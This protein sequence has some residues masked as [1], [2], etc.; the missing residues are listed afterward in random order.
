MVGDRGRD[1][2]ACSLASPCGDADTDRVDGRPARQCPADAV[3]TASQVAEMRIKAEFFNAL[4]AGQKLSHAEMRHSLPRS[5]V[6]FA[7]TERR[8]GGIAAAT[9][10]ASSLFHWR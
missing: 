6:C 5:G 1:S 2:G 3:S 8:I 4:A 7:G 9:L 10:R